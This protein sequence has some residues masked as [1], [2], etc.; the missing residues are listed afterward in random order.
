M[1]TLKWGIL[2]PGRI[3]EKV[4][5][6]I[7]QSE[8]GELYAIGSRSLDK[9]AD[10]A[11]R[12]GAS[13]SYDSYEELCADDKLDI[14]YIATP[15]SFHC[16]HSMIAM[17]HG[18]HVLCEKPFALDA[19]EASQMMNC[20]KKN[21]VFLM[22][23]MWSRF[24]PGMKK[25]K[26]LLAS[27]AIGT[28]KTFTANFCFSS[29]PE[30][31]PRL[32]EPSLGGGAL[33]DVGIY[34]VTLACSFFGFPLKSSAR[35]DLTDKGVDATSYYNLEFV[36]GVKAEMFSS[37][38]QEGDSKAVITGEEG[39]IIIHANCWTLQSITLKNGKETSFHTPYE[40]SDY[41][42]QIEEVNQCIEHGLKESS[43]NS[44]QWT[45]GMMQVMDDLREK[46]GVDYK[47][48][49]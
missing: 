20:A 8:N 15:H 11:K 40:G 32:F 44:F 37:I 6:A 45:Q 34:P 29:S 14:I 48:K 25:V 9:A 23:A 12:F 27:N 28:I 21:N 31:K 2:G 16:E 26:E 22:E 13:K 33:L 39:Q 38:V 24:L 42:L 4:A 1:K 10:F 49:M 5:E 30:Q 7:L 36:N 41:R 17:K 43:V 47:T 3:A 46:M 19:D 35:A 18:K